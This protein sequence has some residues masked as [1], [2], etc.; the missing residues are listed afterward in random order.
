MPSRIEL[1]SLLDFAQSKAR[2]DPTAFPDAPMGEYWTQ[3]LVR[4]PADQAAK[5]NY[6]S[7][8]FGTGN[9]NTDQAT[10]D[11]RYVRCVRSP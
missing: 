1:I 10:S 8:H 7:V 11:H 9:V 5:K 2:I 4:A 6:W 3:S